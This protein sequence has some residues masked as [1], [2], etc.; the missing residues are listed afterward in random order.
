M[1]TS[2]SLRRSEASLPFMSCTTRMPPSSSGCRAS[3]TMPGEMGARWELGWAEV[4][5]RLGRDWAEVGGRWGRDGGGVVGD[6]M[7]ET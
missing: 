3:K 1:S 7:C 2:C 4:G 5:P 6:V